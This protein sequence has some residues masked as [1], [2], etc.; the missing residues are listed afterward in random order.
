MRRILATLTAV[1]VVFP[2][3]AAQ[4]TFVASYGLTTNTAFNC[5]IAK[6]CRQFSEGGL[7]Y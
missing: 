3:F 6:P 4:R 2:A 7:I 5:S 1:A